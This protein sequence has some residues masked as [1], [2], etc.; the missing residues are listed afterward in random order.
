MTTGATTGS[1]TGSSTGNEPAKARRGRP[2]YDQESVLRIATDVFNR[3]GYDGTSMDDLAHELHLS[4]SAIYH[5]V[6]SKEELLRHALAESL[7]ALTAMMDDAESSPGD[8]LARLRW[9]V[10]R[11]V[12]VLVAH[13]PSVTLLLRVHGN[14]P[15]EVEALRRRR[16]IDHRLAVMVQAAAD[17]GAIRRDIEPALVSRLLFGM[18]NSLTEW[19]RHDGRNDP[20]H[21]A[22]AM[23][24]IAFDGLTAD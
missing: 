17:D 11:S 24:L 6:D 4:K 13:L 21:V 12:E 7:D 9:V 1:S 10:S 5:H 20:S 15:V 2:G 16:D 19:Y 18:V 3:R 22:G 23:A 14:S 8:S